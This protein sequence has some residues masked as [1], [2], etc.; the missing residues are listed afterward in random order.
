[1]LYLLQIKN[2]SILSLLCLFFLFSPVTN[3]GIEFFAIGSRR[4]IKCD[5]PVVNKQI[6]SLTKFLV[7][8]LSCKIMSW[9]HL[10]ISEA[11]LLN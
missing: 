8:I 2:N 3:K 7:L 6:K 11:S 4:S 5:I 10:L 9:S 1:M